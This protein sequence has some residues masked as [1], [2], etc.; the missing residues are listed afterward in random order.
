MKSRDLSIDLV[1]VIAMCMVIFLHTGVATVS[2]PYYSSFSQYKQV[3]DGFSCIAVPLFFMVSGFLMAQKEMNW[4]YV[5]DKIWRILKF[6]IITISFVLVCYN[7]VDYIEHS[8]ITSR[9]YGI[10]TYLLWFIQKGYMWQYWYFAA[11]IFMYL[12]SVCF[13]EHLKL[14]RKICVVLLIS[15]LFSFS[16]F[17]LDVICQFEKKFIIQTFRIWY[18]IMYYC[19]GAVMCIYREKFG[20]ITWPIAIIMAV[21][22]SLF[23]YLGPD[24]GGNEYYFGSVLCM[25][26][27]VCVF[28]ACLN[29]HV[30]NG[31]VIKQ[32][33]MLFLPVYA[34]HVMLLTIFVKILNYINVAFNNGYYYVILTVSFG[35]L[36]IL[37][38]WFIM[39]LPYMD[40]VFKL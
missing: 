4:K 3:I 25:I 36:I 31:I 8:C 24:T 34:L 9:S 35:G 32:L 18:W 23:Q 16:F 38:C 26:Y 21:I 20:F 5:K 13:F 2:S 39:K 6:I 22:Y 40:K 15:I 30:K 10:G 17:L 11:M 33:S 37:L 14:S 19:L 12:F 1:K 27:A 7:L 29:T 28:G